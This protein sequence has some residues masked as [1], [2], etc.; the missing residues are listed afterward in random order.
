ML[1]VSTGCMPSR[2]LVWCNGDTKTPRPGARL[3]TEARVMRTIG[4][5]ER[6]WNGCSYRRFVLSCYYLPCASNYTSRLSQ[7]LFK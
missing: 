5:R 7:L 4:R 2:G 1:H 6:G 3:A